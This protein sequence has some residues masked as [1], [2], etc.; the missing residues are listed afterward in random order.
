MRNKKLS[1]YYLQ[2]LNYRLTYT[3]F[4]TALFFFTTYNYKQS[5]IFKIL[6]QGLSHFITAGLTEIFFTY[7]QFCTLLSIGFSIFLGL[8]QIYLFLRPGL[9]YYE[10]KLLLKLLTIFICFYLAVYIF[11]FP[12][13]IKILWE[14]FTLYSQNF[15]PIHLTFEPRLDDYLKN[16][17]QLNK[18]LSLSFPCII[19][20]NVIQKYT[21]KYLWVKHRGVIYILFFLIAAIIT[22][23]DIISQM[24]V[25]IPL[26]LFFELQIIFWTIYNKYQK[27]LLIR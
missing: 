24:L 20:I 22:P 4:G 12:I 27:Q 3:A 17:Q 8:T 16:V 6:P 23:P 26:I 15:T 13:L 11:I 5:L 7:I 14:L 18:I 2:E 21:K 1:L 10:A 25:G 9:Y 19:L